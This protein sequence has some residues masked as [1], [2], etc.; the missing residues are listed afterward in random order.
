MMREIFDKMDHIEY[1]PSKIPGTVHPS[2]FY[3]SR[4]LKST[5]LSQSTLQTF[6][7]NW[8]TNAWMLIQIIAQ[9]LKKF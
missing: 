8:H 7:S 9:L 1:D 3:T 4:I 6:T 2:A 5:N